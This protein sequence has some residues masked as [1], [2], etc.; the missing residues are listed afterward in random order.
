MALRAFITLVGLT[1]AAPAQAEMFELYGTREPYQCGPYAFEPGHT[2]TGEEAA[3]IYVCEYEADP[4]GIGS[5]LFLIED[6]EL[7]VG[8]P[9]QYGTSADYALFDADSSQPLFPV[10]GSLTVVQCKTLSDRNRGANCTEYPSDVDGTCFA[11]TFAEWRC[12]FSL[13]DAGAWRT[14]I[15]PRTTS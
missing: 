11:T 14:N 6:I 7:Q 4:V 9:R 8:S 10:R 15:P 12:V 13:T 3:A 5:N 2:L 1:L